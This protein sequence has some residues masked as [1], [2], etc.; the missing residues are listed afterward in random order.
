MDDLVN[1]GFWILDVVF[2]YFVIKSVFALW[3]LRNTY[4]LA[5]TIEEDILDRLETLVHNV[6]TEKHAD[7]DYWFDEEN[8]TFFAQGRNLDEIRS[9]LKERFTQDVFMV[10]G[11]LLLTGPDYE[12]MDISNKTP[13]EVGKYVA[14]TVVKKMIPK[15]IQ[16]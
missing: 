3:E 11:K 15:H 4:K 16:D 5:K 13:S 14:E 6:K 2:W 8:D 10:N 7:V 1:F 12:P 9:H